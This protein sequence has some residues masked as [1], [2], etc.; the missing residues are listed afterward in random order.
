MTDIAT[1]TP[2]R[3]HLPALPATAD[4]LASSAS[5]E[6][7][8]R[9][10]KVFCASDLI[11]AHL[12]KNNGADA[13]LALQIAKR[14]GED[15]VAV[16]QNIYFVSGKAGWSASYMIARAN[17]SGVFKGP[18]RWRTEGE[19]DALVVTARG[20]LVEIE[21]EDVEVS[22]S[23]LM[24]KAEGWTKNAKYNT[25]AEHMLRWR[26]ATMLIRLYCPEVMMGM[27]TQDELEDMHAAGQLRDVTAEGDATTAAQVGSILLPPENQPH[28]Q[29]DDGSVG[30][31]K[32]EAHAAD[33]SPQGVTAPSVA[34]AGG[35]ET[36]PGLTAE[37]STTAVNWRVPDGIVGQENIISAIMGLI[38]KAP[39]RQDVD[40]VLLQNSERCAKFSAIKRDEIGRYAANRKL[41]IEGVIA[42]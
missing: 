26:S 9:V 25:M 2:I 22:V 34:S 40:A 6:H 12:K 1:V 5:F 4:I 36:A 42:R 41:D 13:L 31:S 27:P 39:R 3:P 10:A 37:D 16:M 15:P 7:M 30:D 28:T 33:F 21:G 29:G 23:M 38:D 17:R 18:I 32:S 19:G 14:M 8:Q 20:R 24:A 11:P 35:V